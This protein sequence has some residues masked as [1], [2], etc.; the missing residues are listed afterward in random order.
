M[1]QE[2]I[3]SNGIEKLRGEVIYINNNNNCVLIVVE[4]FIF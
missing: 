2:E 4:G 1:T 3:S